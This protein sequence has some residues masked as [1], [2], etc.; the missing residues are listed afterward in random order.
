MIN[1]PVELLIRE[2][3]ARA[4]AEE[5]EACAKIAEKMHLQHGRSNFDSA[6][7]DPGISYELGRSDESFSVASL[8]RARARSEVHA[9]EEVRP[10]VVSG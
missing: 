3:V 1:N 5:R 10:D 7:A 2:A 4:I 6:D 8:I 9:V